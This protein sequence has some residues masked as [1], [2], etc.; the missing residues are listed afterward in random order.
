MDEI[1][2]PP[3][4]EPNQNITFC[5][6]FMSIGQLPYRPTPETIARI[7]ELL[8]LTQSMDGTAPADVDQVPPADHRFGLPRCS[9]SCTP[10]GWQKSASASPGLQRQ[11]AVMLAPQSPPASQTSAA[12]INSPSISRWNCRPGCGALLRRAPAPAMSRP[13]GVPLMRCGTRLAP[14]GNLLGRMCF[15]RSLGWD[16][17]THRS[18]PV[19]LPRQAALVA[20]LAMHDC[21]DGFID[22]WRDNLD[23][24]RLSVGHQ[25]ALLPRLF[26]LI[27]FA[28]ETLP[29]HSVF[30]KAAEVVE[31][32]RDPL[33]RRVGER[34]G[35]SWY[36]ILLGR[37]TRPF[38]VGVA[39]RRL[40]KATADAG[41]G[42]LTGF[43]EYKAA[44]AGKAF[45]KCDRWYPS[46]KA[47]SECGSICDK[48]PLDVR[49]WTCANCSAHHDR[50]INAA[51]NIRDEG[52]RILA[53]G[54]VASASRG[55]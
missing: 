10:A 12:P 33:C 41:W 38:R 55:M 54:A 21:G 37:R 46:S 52:L 17:N 18:L 40:A 6:P 28:Q 22:H 16:G 49:A 1:Q 48:M 24:L 13:F 32:I 2:P 36:P 9:A 39:N 8:S 26:L 20:G 25:A 47:C 30:G 42:M 34:V 31:E 23:R 7:A 35:H 4:P 5:G 51:R 43:I 45:L 14:M 53:A 3:A 29:H 15:W 19:S 27:D 50:D 11:E 44:R